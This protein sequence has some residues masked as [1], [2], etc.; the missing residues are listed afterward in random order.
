MH[1]PLILGSLAY[2]TVLS[3]IGV[4]GG[5]GDENAPA[6]IASEKRQLVGGCAGN[7]AYALRKLGDTPVIMATGGRDFDLYEK[8]LRE[9]D[10]GAAHIK[11]IGDDHTA[12]AYIFNDERNR[13]MIFFHPGRD[14]LRG[15]PRSG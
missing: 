13:Q 12:Q 4:F 3:V 15:Q 5:Q 6:Y 11:I 10:I 9:H 1:S 14:R 8:H 7:I 2:D